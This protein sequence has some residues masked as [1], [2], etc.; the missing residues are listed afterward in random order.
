MYL[1]YS[2]VK[3]YTQIFTYFL[4]MGFRENLKAELEY[5][6]ISVGDLASKTGISKRT[7]EKYLCSEG[8]VPLADTAC[9]IAEALGVSVE[10]LVNGTNRQNDNILTNFSPDIRHIIRIAENSSHAD[11]KILLSLA[12]ALCGETQN[13]IHAQILRLLSGLF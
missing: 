11:R 5:N 10:Q 1:K 7:L 3:P 8:S 2:I 12:R 13:P 6:G 4:I 9:K